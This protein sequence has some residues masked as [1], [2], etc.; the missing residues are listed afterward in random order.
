MITV[1]I[2]G[3][4]WKPLHLL[5]GFPEPDPPGQ[6]DPGVLYFAAGEVY[7]VGILDLSDNQTLY[8]EGGATLRGMIRIRDASNVRILGRGMIDG[9]INTSNGNDPDGDEP[10]RLVYMDHSEHI[11]IE[12]ITFYNSLRWT[13]HPYSC[14]DIKIN[15]IRILNWNYGSDGIDVSACQHVHITRCFLHTNDDAVAVKALSFGENMFYPNPREPN[16]NV[17]NIVVEGCTVWNMD[18]GNAFEIGYELRCDTVSEIIFRDCDVLR[19][20]GRG[21]VISIHNSDNAV[22][23]NILYEDIRIVNAE[24]GGIG[25]KLFDLAIFYSLFSYDSYWGDINPN[26]H[27]DNL[28][29]PWGP[30]G[31]AE[32]RG[33]IRDVTFRDIQVMDENLAYSIIRGWDADHTIE[34]VT[35]DNITYLGSHMSSKEDLNLQLFNEHHRNVLFK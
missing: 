2:N 18:W 19:Q 20:G 3:K 21:A 31:A 4:M 27:W 13:I 12:G 22:V 14:K 26:G 30:Y 10:W 32:F 11:E 35:F 29:S 17:K 1:L 24:S 7:D 33:K 6:D 16:M 15:N 34:N 23:E 5:A 9:S 8:I 25:K 28:L